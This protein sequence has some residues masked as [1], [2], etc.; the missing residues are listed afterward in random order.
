MVITRV[1]NYDYI[2]IEL[3]SRPFGFISIIAYS[4]SPMRIINECIFSNKYWSKSIINNITT[5]IAIIITLKIPFGIVEVIL[6]II[7]IL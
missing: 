4:D 1:S 2:L 6:Q 7:H 3:W 5:V